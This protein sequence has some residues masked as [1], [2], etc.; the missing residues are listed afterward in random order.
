MV[1]PFIK[2]EDNGLGLGRK[3]IYLVLVITTESEMRRI[4]PDGNIE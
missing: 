3:I 2:T 1:V 4:P